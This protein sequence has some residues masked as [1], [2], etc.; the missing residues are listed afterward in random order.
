MLRPCTAV[1]GSLGIFHVRL[2][3]VKLLR[4]YGLAGSGWKY[5][6]HPC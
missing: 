1:E 4:L 5:L 3:V 2:I 6:I